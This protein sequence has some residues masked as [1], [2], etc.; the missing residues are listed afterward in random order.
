MQPPVRLHSLREQVI[1]LRRR[2]KCAIPWHCYVRQRSI[3]STFDEDAP[4]CLLVSYMP[5]AR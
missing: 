5:L 1:S 3:C 4:G 2:D